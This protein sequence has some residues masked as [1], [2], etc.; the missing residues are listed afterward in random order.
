M[1]LTHIAKTKQNKYWKC[2]CIANLRWDRLLLHR[3]LKFSRKRKKPKKKESEMALFFYHVNTLP[4]PFSHIY[5]G[6]ERWQVTE[7]TLGVC[8]SFL[9]EKDGDPE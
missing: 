9:V 6:T 5:Y 1:S 8:F 3:L 2:G 4:L 7:V